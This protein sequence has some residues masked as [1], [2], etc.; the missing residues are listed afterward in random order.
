MDAKWI[1]RAGSAV[2][3]QIAS[4]I[5]RPA[6]STTL[7]SARLIRVWYPRPCFLNQANT[8]ASSRSVTGFLIGLYISPNS[9]EEPCQPLRSP[10]DAFRFILFLPALRL[11]VT[12]ALRFIC[13]VYT[14][15]LIHTT[16]HTILAVQYVPRGTSVDISAQTSASSP[17]A[18]QD[19]HVSW[20]L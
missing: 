11:P 17:R 8:S 20:W 15:P 7:R 2:E 1:E 6:S 3:I 4:R 9:V 14:H 18:C 12:L 16:I 10:A 5:Y 19:N 13:A